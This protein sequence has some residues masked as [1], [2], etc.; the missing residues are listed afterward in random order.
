[1]PSQCESKILNAIHSTEDNNTDQS[2][3]TIVKSSIMSKTVKTSRWNRPKIEKKKWKGNIRMRKT[4][5]CYSIYCATLKSSIHIF[6]E[7]I[8]FP[9]ICRCYLWP[10]KKE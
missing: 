9:I 5:S 4:I 2:L 3:N 6:L 1:M 8:S 10:N 7:I